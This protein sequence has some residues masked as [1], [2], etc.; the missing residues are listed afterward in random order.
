[1]LRRIL[2]A[3]ALLLVCA[4]PDAR[5]QQVFVRGTDNK[6]WGNWDDGLGWTGWQPLG[7]QSIYS[8][9]DACASASDLVS[10]VALL[11]DGS[12]ALRQRRNDTWG[13]WRSLG[14]RFTSA[15]AIT[16]SVGGLDIFAR[17][18]NNG[19]WHYHLNN[20][21][22]I[23]DWHDLEGRWQEGPDAATTGPDSVFVVARGQEGSIWIKGYAGGQWGSWVSLG[24]SFNSA[25]SL[26]AWGARGQQPTLEAFARGAGNAI[27]HARVTAFAPL[28]WTSLG[29]E[30]NGPPSA[31]AWTDDGRGALFSPSW[32]RQPPGFQIFARGTREDVRMTQCPNGQCEAWTSLGATISDGPGAAS[33]SG[34]LVSDRGTYRI[35][36]SH[37]M[38]NA[39]TI[40]HALSADGK[41]D[42]VIVRTLV[43]QFDATA[44]PAAGRPALV[45]RS[46][47]IM[48]DTNNLSD[49]IKAGSISAA[50]G[51][52]AGDTIPAAGA[53]PREPR[54]DAIPLL[55]WEG[56]LR[57][58]ATGV[59]V[60]P[61]IWEYD[62]PDSPLEPQWPYLADRWWTA[63]L[64]SLVE[65]TRYDNAAMRPIPASGL[66]LRRPI[67]DAL[68]AAETRPIGMTRTV[69]SEVFEPRYLL[70]T[71]RSVERE[72]RNPRAPARGVI[73][74]GYND[75]RELAGS[76]TLRITVERLQ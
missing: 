21:G 7:G 33:G 43:S 56:E 70:F 55:V 24:G 73:L 6:L 12:T 9:P 76:Y 38:V 5:A 23:V 60:L 48:G 36:I 41:G 16:C 25:P 13:E 19:I 2:I 22:T 18:T 14:G 10:V 27:Y 42:E 67:P 17:G 71:F 61:T 75:A 8:A 64:P 3:T 68:S 69:N 28:Q 44:D 53:L 49:R 37:V 26:I 11:E 65:Q 62:G 34:P 46:T 35:T 4:A 45:G 58:R 20:D 51:L 59:M 29:G 30:F 52:Q 63:A 72:L 15:P 54:T 31:A 47:R 74:V 32:E 1:M 57:D 40:D 66:Q 50:G 39:A